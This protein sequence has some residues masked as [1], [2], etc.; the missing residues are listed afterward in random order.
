MNENS[1]CI[2]KY[3][4]LVHSGRR[5]SWIISNIPHYASLSPSSLAKTL[6]RHDNSPSDPHDSWRNHARFFDDIFKCIF[7]FNPTVSLGVF[8][9]MPLIKR[10][11]TFMTEVVILFCFPFQ[12][13]CSLTWDISLQIPLSEDDILI[14]CSHF[15]VL[16]WLLHIFSYTLALPD[17]GF[18]HD[19]I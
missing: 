11:R 3:R 19:F 12:P 15:R 2:T 17:E 4:I 10:I 16:F 13:F 14:A 1:Q 8:K 5:T 18:L 7:L 9:N 6:V